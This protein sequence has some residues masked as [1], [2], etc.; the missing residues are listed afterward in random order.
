MKRFL[1][2]VALARVCHDAN[3]AYCLGLGDTSQESWD[4][5]PEWQ[6]RSAIDGV[7][8]HLDN[9]GLG[10]WQ[11]HERWR[12]FK[13]SE[14]WTHGPVK[15]PAKREHPCLVPFEKLPLE[16]QIKDKLFTSIVQALRGFV[17][18]PS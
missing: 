15:D 4:D 2:E 10:Y 6:R 7:R 13:E 14:G 5:A 18:V 3:R 17:V 12:Q 1:T 11:G 16:Q 8:Y 9:P